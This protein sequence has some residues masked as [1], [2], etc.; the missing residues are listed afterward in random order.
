M[1]TV[2]GHEQRRDGESRSRSVVL[3]GFMATGK[4]TV[5]RQ[6]A[7]R[8]RYGFVDTD[9]LIEER[10]GPVPEIF[11]THGEERFRAI[12][13]ELA[14]ELAA[15]PALVIATGGGMLVDSAVADVFI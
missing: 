13:R 10:F 5:G 7:A 1:T 15:L 6:L 8:L 11:R 12:E 4:S 3:T 14:S 2:S 9:R